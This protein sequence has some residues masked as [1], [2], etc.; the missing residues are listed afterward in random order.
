[1]QK[2]NLLNISVGLAFIVAIFIIFNLKFTNY[3]SKYNTYKIYVDNVDGIKINTSV[4]I[5]GRKIGFVRNLNLDEQNNA[6][7]NALVLK[8][9]KIPTDSSFFVSVP[10]LFASNKNINIILGIN[11]EYLVNNDVVYNSNLGLDLNGMLDLINIYLKSLTQ[12]VK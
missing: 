4:N 9:I 6:Y 11:E 12:Q 8:S 5:G 3:A 7:I 2:N 1:M 10:S